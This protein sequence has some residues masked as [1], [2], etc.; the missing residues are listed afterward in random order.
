[1]DI[2]HSINITYLAELFSTLLR[3]EKEVLNNYSQ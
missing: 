2:L 3:Y 1:M